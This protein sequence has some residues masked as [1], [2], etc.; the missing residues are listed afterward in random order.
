MKWLLSNPWS[1]C[2]LI[3]LNPFFW[4]G[5][6]M[7]A[8]YVFTGGI[9]HGEDIGSYPKN[10]IRS[11]N[12]LFAM[13]GIISLIF[14]IKK[15]YVCLLLYGIIGLSHYVFDLAD[16]WFRF[17]FL[18]DPKVDP[19]SSTY[20]FV[21]AIPPWSLT[22]SICPPSLQNSPPHNVCFISLNLLKIILADT[23]LI[24]CITSLGAYLGA[25]PTR[26]CK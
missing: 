13:A 15:L 14:R 12:S 16:E 2:V 22:V 1:L 17:L 24:I 9:I 8:S 25:A 7:I 20:F 26:M 19:F 11:V 21:L 10:I 18:L 4:L 5:L 3:L 6:L 23:L